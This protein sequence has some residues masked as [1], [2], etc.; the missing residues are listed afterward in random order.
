VRVGFVSGLN[1]VF[2][3]GAV[4][5]LVSAVLTLVLIRSQDFETGAARRTQAAPAA[6]QAGHRPTE[7]AE[8]AV[9]P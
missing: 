5:C 1:D 3:I 6:E 7:S 4:L 8:T 2:L 9:T